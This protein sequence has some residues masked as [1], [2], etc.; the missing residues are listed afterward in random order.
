M[1]DSDTT[2]L[3]DRDAAVREWEKQTQG[4]LIASNLA[5][6]KG[7][8]AIVAVAA[9]ALGLVWYAKNGGAEAKPQTGADLGIAERKPVPKLKIEQTSV[10]SDPASAPTSPTP[11]T[12]AGAESAAPNAGDQLEAQR[13]DQE[14]RMLEARMK[15]AIIPP[16]VA[17][18]AN[19][20]GP[21]SEVATAVS[22]DAGPTPASERGA[23]DANSRFARAVSTG[24]AVPVSVAG[25]NDHLEYKILQGKLVEAVL[26]PRAVSDLP[27]TL[28]ATVQRDVYGAQ[29]R[30]ALI[31]WGSRVCGVYSAE[32]RKGQDRL[33]AVWNT[34]RRPDGVQVTLDSIG[35]DQLGTAGMGGVV[36]RHFAEIFG[37]STLIS[38]VGAGAA[39][40]GV[41]G[42]DQYNSAAFYRQSVQQAAAQTSQQALQ[43]YL[44]IQPS[45]T[46]P[47]GERIR[48]YVN[49][50]LDFTP[51]YRDELDA[52]AAD[53]ATLIQ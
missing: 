34:L 37:V 32:L 23:E 35:A 16:N 17:A 29:G 42:S 22:P 20:T 40:V 24:G 47:P 18:Q 43:P 6:K 12:T 8:T 3:G 31:P 39:N 48:I 9:M 36:D 30:K 14:R 46:V 7:G 15:S 25:R 10:P 11:A 45:V 4:P 19:P 1:N 49:R 28:C 52:E 51:V 21:G 38:I 27:G 5:K 53:R 44:A 50:D 33:F 13:R 2:P 26:E 41:S